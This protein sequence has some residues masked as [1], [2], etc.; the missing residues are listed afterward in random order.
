M[1]SYLSRWCAALLIQCLVRQ[2]PLMNKISKWWGSFLYVGIVGLIISVVF[3]EYMSQFLYAHYQTWSAWRSI[4]GSDP[5]SLT[6]IIQKITWAVFFFS[7]WFM[8][9]KLDS[10]FL[11]P[12]PQH[13]ERKVGTDSEDQENEGNTKEER[14]RES[15]NRPKEDEVVIE[16]YDDI[17][18]NSEKSTDVTNDEFFT[19]E[20]YAF[21]EILG[22]GKPLDLTMI[23]STYRKTIAQYHPDRVMAM[24]PEIK[25]V[26]EKK[27][28][29]I[30]EAYHYFR[31]KF[32]LN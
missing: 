15:S 16:T 1:G 22:L 31:K 27:A 14:K 4:V 8:L 28:K 20:D 7:S 30:N 23:K 13:E 11:N 26:A 5:N 25:E 3:S 29:E 17:P 21:A 9:W 12:L 18:P 10:F 19:A 2:I 24:G 6:L 32:E